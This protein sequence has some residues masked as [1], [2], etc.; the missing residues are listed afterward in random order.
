MRHDP[1][2]RIVGVCDGV[3][4]QIGHLRRIDVGE[5]EQAPREVGGIIVRA[6]Y[7]AELGVEDRLELLPVKEMRKTRVKKAPEVTN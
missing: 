3:L 4:Q 7:T 1:T 2:P 5:S 6:E